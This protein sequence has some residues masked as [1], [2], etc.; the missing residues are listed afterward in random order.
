MGCIQF[1]P[2]DVCGINAQLVLRS[3]VAAFTKQLFDEVLYKDR[4]LVDYFDKNLAIFAVEDWPYFARRR[5]MHSKHER[6]REKLLDKSQEFLDIIK[7]KGPMCSKDFGM[8]D[9]IDWYWSETK[10]SRAMLEHLYFT[11]KLAVH[12]KKGSNKYYDL[13]ERCIPA[14]IL[15]Q[16]EPLP[17][18]HE[19]YKWRALRRIGAIGLLWNRGSD[20][21][22]DIQG[23][24]TPERNAAFAALLEEGKIV[25]VEV[26][27][28]KEP[29]YMRTE[30]HPLLDKVIT[31]RALKKRC[32]AIAPL[33]CFIWDRKL[34]N[35][36][37][38]FSYTWEIYTPAEKRKYGHYVLPVIYGTR[39]IGRVEAVRGDGHLLIKNFWPEETKPLTQGEHA[40]LSDCFTR[41]AQFN[42]FEG[43]MGFDR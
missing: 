34:I 38:G 6:N 1:D 39:F 30:D 28:I 35:A 22:L 7:A 3:R 41:L 12:H 36:L 17:T 15:A 40:A 5:S 8:N 10:L 24:K 4:T 16:G 33:D 18:D 19:H 27:G 37:F 25:P 31:A 29:L 21:W 11:G 23:F 26:E 20:A 42:G 32:E 9:K 13:I 2:V 43:Y 14:D